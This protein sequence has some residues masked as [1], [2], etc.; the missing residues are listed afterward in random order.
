MT[1]F[2]NRLSQQDLADAIS[3][4]VE[5]EAQRIE[6]IT[7]DEVEHVAGGYVQGPPEGATMGYF[8]SSR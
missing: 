2:P 3:A 6:Q 8:P 1:G 7:E 4:A 5:I